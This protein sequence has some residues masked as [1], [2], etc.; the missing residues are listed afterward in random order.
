[1]A[2]R[3]IVVLGD[4]DIRSQVRATLKGE[5]EVAIIGEFCAL[6]PRHVGF[7]DDLAPDMVILDCSSRTIN[8]L[9]AT[10]DL[11]RIGAHPEVIAILADGGGVD[12][13]AIA[14][15][16]AASI[17]NSPRA[18]RDAIG[19]TRLPIVPSQAHGVAA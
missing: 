9:L 3:T 15:M 5:R 7:I 19:L 6:Q 4:E 10:A 8:P 11:A 12:F 18:L 1:M 17:A 14:R 13:R 16:G 2:A